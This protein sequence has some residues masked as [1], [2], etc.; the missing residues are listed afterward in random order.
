MEWRPSI[1][2]RFIQI[3]RTHDGVERTICTSVVTDV[4]RE[5][6]QVQVKTAG[7]PGY[8]LRDKPLPWRPPGLSRASEVAGFEYWWRHLTYV[9]ELPNPSLFPPLATP[10]SNETAAKVERFITVTERLAEST[11]ISSRGGMRMIPDQ[12]GGNDVIETNFPSADAQAGFA[13]LLRQCHVT[14]EPASYDHVRNALWIA[15]SAATDD[16]VLARQA[17]LRAW[18]RSVKSLRRRS[19]DQLVRDKLVQEEQCG[20]FAWQ[21]DDSP[22]ELLRTFN[23]GD[24]IHWGTGRR[25]LSNSD[26]EYLVA[27]QRFRFFNAALGLAHVYIGF[28]QL[29]RAATTPLSRLLTP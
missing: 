7:A 26:D 4:V 28:G 1:P 11:T 15:S 8:L 22:E 5:G 29:L 13:V 14:D 25:T 3:V 6:D 12:N 23:Y 27:Q 24:L 2:D 9:F 16:R 21:E 19:L 18:H 20:V 10:L 17:D